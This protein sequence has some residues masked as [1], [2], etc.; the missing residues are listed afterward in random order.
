MLRHVLSISA[1]TLVLAGAVCPASAQLRE[2]KHDGFWISF[3]VGGGRNY[4]KDLDGGDLDGGGGYLRM[5]GTPSEQILIGGE[6]I[7]WTRQ[8]NGGTLAR[9]NATFTI[10][11]YPSR[12]GD[13]FIKGGIGGGSLQVS[14]TAL[15]TTVTQSQNGAGETIGIGYDVRVGHNLYITPNLDFL[16]EQVTNAGLTTHNAISLLTIG[17]TWH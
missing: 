8:E 13:F 14:S 10:E 4:N 2:R 1:L 5:G 17:L 9:G 12:D 11:F 3:G 15:G 7:G 16:F 6:V